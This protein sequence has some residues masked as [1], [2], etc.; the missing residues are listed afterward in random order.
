MIKCLTI[1]A[2]IIVEENTFRKKIPTD[3]FDVRW[4]DSYSVMLTPG[5]GT[6]GGGE[7]VVLNLTQFSFTTSLSSGNRNFDHIRPIPI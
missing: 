6:V 5:A 7:F 2:L 4:K 1:I 3:N